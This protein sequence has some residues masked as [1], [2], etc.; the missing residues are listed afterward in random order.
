MK[1]K[2]EHKY[3]CSS[4]LMDAVRALDHKAQYKVCYAFYDAIIKYPR[5]DNNRFCLLFDE[6]YEA[7]DPD[8]LDFVQILQ[9]E[10]VRAGVLPSD[11][12]FEAHK[13]LVPMQ[14]GDVPTTY[15]DATALERDFGFTPKITLR[16]GLRKFAEWYKEYYG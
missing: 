11:F 4:D 6:I 12:D 5:W 8:A 9:E 15:A 14:P 10:L 1:E 16:E 2:M 3:S 13:E 7:I